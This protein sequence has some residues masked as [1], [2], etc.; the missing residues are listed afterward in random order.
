MKA[1]IK[2]LVHFQPN[3]YAPAGS[4]PALSIYPFDMS[5]HGYVLIGSVDIE[6][7]L[8]DDFNPLQAEIGGL[9]KQLDILAEKY[10]T[11][12][13]AIRERISNLQCIEHTPARQ[14]GDDSDF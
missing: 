5:E 2:C 11:S 12:A 3:P 7:D 14:A 1:V 10:H 9:N 6:Y 8:P 4:A 13:A